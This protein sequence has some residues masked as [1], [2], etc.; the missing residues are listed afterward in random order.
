MKS[1]FHQR[2]EEE[3]LISERLRTTILAA[4]FLFGTLYAGTILLFFNDRVAQPLQKGGAIRMFAFLF[5]LFL[6]EILSLLYI[7]RHKKRNILKFPVFGQYLNAA[8]EITAPGVIMYLLASRFGSGEKVLHSPVSYLYFIFIILSTL[9]LNFRISFFMGL[10]AGIEFLVVGYLL[11]SRHDNLSEPL[12]RDEYFMSTGKALLLFLSGIGAAFV[13]RQ[14]KLGVDRSLAAA[15]QATKITGLFGQQ[16]SKEIVDEMLKNGGEVQT[17]SMDVCIMFVDIRNFTNHVAHKTPSEIVEYQNAFFSIVVRVINK[18]NGIINQFLGD[19]CMVTFGAPVPK[20]NAGLYAVR[21]AIEL[22]QEIASEVEKKN[23]PMT[24]IGIG[25]HAGEAVTGNIGSAQRQQY[26]VTR[27][28]VI[29]AARIE[30][31]NKEFRSE[32][33]ASAEVMKQVK[34]LP[35]GSSDFLGEINLK[36]W[37]VPIGI[38]RLG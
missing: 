34:H 1:I 11:I 32:I 21:A 27:I 35:I 7:N 26:S 24:T 31:L 10:L 3:V 38:Y 18:H 2:F 20:E 29:L 14:I 30:Q 6:F 8:I 13:A 37:S 15:E 25:L 19:G 16:V 12:K 4:M 36:G 28:V 9:R 17:K 23:L 5:L 22:K 33:L